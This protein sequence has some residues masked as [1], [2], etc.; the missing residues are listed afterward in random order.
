[1]K[2][3]SEFH[4]QGVLKAGIWAIHVNV[5]ETEFNQRTYKTPTSLLHTTVLNPDSDINQ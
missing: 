4:L 2:S 1:M 5:V 3:I